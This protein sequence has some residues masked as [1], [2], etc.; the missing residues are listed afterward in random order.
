MAR[1]GVTQPVGR[2]RRLNAGRPGRALHRAEQPAFNPTTEG[3]FATTRWTFQ[4]AVVG[5]TPTTTLAHNHE[6]CPGCWSSDWIGLGRAKIP[7]GWSSS[8]RATALLSCSLL[9]TDSIGAA[10]S[11]H[12]IV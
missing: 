6:P 5:S 1:V 9:P 11:V 10:T 8:P 12:E 7:Y 3:K 4:A 2:D